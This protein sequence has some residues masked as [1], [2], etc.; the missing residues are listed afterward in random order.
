MSDAP[1]AM[2]DASDIDARTGSAAIREAR[3]EVLGLVHDA[4][5]YVEAEREYW[6]GRAAF[7]GKALKSASI[8]G[9]VLAGLVVGLLSILALGGLLILAAFYG[10]IAATLIMAG[11]LLLLS[12]IVAFALTRTVKS[13]KFKND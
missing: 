5:A 2:N 7:T 9:V 13:L 12:A 3:D 6:L 4:R 10:P 1:D 8:L 11:V